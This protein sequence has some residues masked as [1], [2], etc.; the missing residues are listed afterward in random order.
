[1]E[2]SETTELPPIDTLK[3]SENDDGSFTMEWD[4][5]DPLWSWLNTMT[6]DEITEI[7]HNYAK[8]VLQNEKIDSIITNDSLTP[9]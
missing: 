9:D 2:H 8:E 7:I 4:P 5:D 3:V 1:M 6:E